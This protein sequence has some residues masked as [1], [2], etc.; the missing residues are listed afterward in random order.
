MPPGPHFDNMWELIN[1]CIDKAPGL[2]VVMAAAVGLYKALKALLHAP[3]EEIRRELQTNG[4][5]SLKDAVK[6]VQASVAKVETEVTGLTKETKTQTGKLIRLE[7]GH[8]QL[9][10]GQLKTREFLTPLLDAAKLDEL[11]K[12]S[13]KK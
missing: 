8:A 13:K 12:R 5:G 9:R 7:K 2:A 10:A 3:L 4:G 11:T 1:W 6:E